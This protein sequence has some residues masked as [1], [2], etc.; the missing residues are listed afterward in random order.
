M[1][2]FHVSDHSGSNK[3]ELMRI[4]FVLPFVLTFDDSIADHNRDRVVGEDEE[5]I[6]GDVDAEL[7]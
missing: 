1:E 5:E 7:E 2:W 6:A 4:I 3:T